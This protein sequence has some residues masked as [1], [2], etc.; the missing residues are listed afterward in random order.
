MLLFVL[1]SSHNRWTSS[2]KSS[3]DLNWEE[4][5]GVCVPSKGKQSTALNDAYCKPTDNNNGEE[6]E[7]WG[8]KPALNSL[9]NPGDYINRSLFLLH[10]LS[11][12]FGTLCAHYVV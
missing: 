12:P 11:F 8:D 5:W 9:C 4:D 7:Y 3:T 1:E 6:D 2:V 10:T